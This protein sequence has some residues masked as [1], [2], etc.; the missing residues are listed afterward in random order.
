[1][2]KIFYDLIIAR[3]QLKTLDQVPVSIRSKVHDMLLD[4]GYDDNG[5]PIVTQ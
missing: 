3:P 1:M 4:N 2:V 5:N